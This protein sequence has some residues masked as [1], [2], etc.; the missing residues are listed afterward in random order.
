MPG[1]HSKYSG[2]YDDKDSHIP[3][4]NNEACS[5]IGDRQ[6]NALLLCIA[7]LNHWNQPGTDMGF[8]PVGHKHYLLMCY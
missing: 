4:L 2:S 8:H 3:P 5:S 1:N 7:S 6:L